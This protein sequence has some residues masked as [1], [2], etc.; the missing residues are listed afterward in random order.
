MTEW[1]EESTGNLERLD[2]MVTRILTP[3]AKYGLLD[4]VVCLAG[5]VSHVLFF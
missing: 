4:D 1:A 2:A 3:M 5:M